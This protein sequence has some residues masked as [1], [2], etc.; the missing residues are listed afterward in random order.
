MEG[1][2]LPAMTTEGEQGAPQQATF[3][4]KEQLRAFGTYI[5]KRARSHVVVEVS[6]CATWEL[7]GCGAALAEPDLLGSGFAG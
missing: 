1:K 4:V 5:G 2:R 7:Q 3:P 6:V